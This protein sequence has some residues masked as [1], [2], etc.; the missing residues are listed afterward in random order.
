MSVAPRTSSV[1]TQS[2]CSG[3]QSPT[4]LFPTREK[5]ILLS[6]RAARILAE[7]V[8]VRMTPLG[9]FDRISASGRRRLPKGVA[10]SN[11]KLMKCRSQLCWAQYTSAPRSTFD[12]NSLTVSRLPSIKVIV[13]FFFAARVIPSL[14]AAARTPPIRRG[15]AHPRR[16]PRFG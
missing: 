14:R 4:M 9:R 15:G 8:P 6:E 13:R 16:R 7:C 11:R 12:W 5:G 10:R 2:Y 1:K 3:C